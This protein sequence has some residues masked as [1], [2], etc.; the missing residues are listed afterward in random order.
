MVLYTPGYSIRIKGIPCENLKSVLRNPAEIK[1]VNLRSLIINLLAQARDS[2]NKWES[3]KG[4]PFT[5][6]CLI[7]HVGCECNFKCTYCYASIDKTGNRNMRG[8]PDPIAIKKVAGYITEQLKSDSPKMVLAFH[9]AG[10]PSY[11]WDR[12]TNT[13]QTIK[14]ISELN[15]VKLFKYIATNGCLDEKQTRWL[16]EN[17]DLIGLSCD[18]PPDIQFT[19]RGSGR[20]NHLPVEKICRII[21]STGGRFDFRVT[22]TPETVERLPEIAEYLIEECRAGNIRVEPVYLAGDK[23]F[24]EEDAEIFFNKFITARD[25]AQKHKTGISY[26]GVR[27]H[28]LHSTY[29]DVSRNVIRL[30]ADGKTRNCFCFISDREGFI[31]GKYNYSKSK[32]ILKAD[33]KELKN[34]AFTIPDDC[35]NCINIYHCSRGCPDFCLFEND[36]Y[37]YPK[38]NS[39]RCRLHQLIAVDYAVAMAVT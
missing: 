14:K 33:I 17:M 22:V 16:A 25:L 9:G 32:F 21:L 27:I 19:Q 31:T 24:R 34:K 39:F 29:C 10:E 7:I 26:P 3:Q 8:F 5:P 12:L 23:G 13:L 30:T 2:V 11:N 18:G 4:S 20:N 36:Y 35:Y 1:D 38:L 37:L 6:E 15:D 28:E